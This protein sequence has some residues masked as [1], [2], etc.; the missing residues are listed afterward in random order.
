[1]VRPLSAKAAFAPIQHV[2]EPIFQGLLARTIYIRPRPHNAFRIMTSSF[3]FR[4]LNAKGHNLAALARV[5]APAH[6]DHVL[7]G[8]NER[9]QFET[10]KLR[11]MARHSHGYL[12]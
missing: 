12:M 11:S 2:I 7:H 5:L 4:H 1:M 8:Q 6:N 9:L 10:N 3:H